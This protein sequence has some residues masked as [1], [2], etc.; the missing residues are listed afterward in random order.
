MKSRR[1]ASSRQSSVKATVARRPGFTAG[2][3]L[4]VGRAQQGEAAGIVASLNGAAYI[5]APAIGVWIYGRDP[6]VVF[7]LIAG[8]CV[9]LVAHGWR[10]LPPDVAA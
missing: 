8:L 7:A 6:W 5:V 4:A 2:S 9:A 3:S 1:A 10:H